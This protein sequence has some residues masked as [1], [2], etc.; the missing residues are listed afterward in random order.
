MAGSVLD[1]DGVVGMRSSWDRVAVVG[2][3]GT[4][5]TAFCTAARG[6]GA[7][8]TADA[9]LERYGPDAAITYLYAV[10]REN[11]ANLTPLRHLVDIAC[12]TAD[13]ATRRR[14][15]AIVREIAR[16]VAVEDVEECYRLLERLWRDGA[17]GQRSDETPVPVEELLRAV[18]QLTRPGDADNP[19]APPWSD[20]EAVQFRLS[21]VRIVLSGD[22]S[23]QELRSRLAAAERTLERA[24]AAATGLTEA[25]R[26]L[27]AMREAVGTGK[28]TRTW[29]VQK[30]IELTLALK[31][32]LDAGDDSCPGAVRLAMELM[33]NSE[34]LLEQAQRR[35][36]S[37]QLARL[38]D[39]VARL[40]EALPPVDSEP[41]CACP[42]A[43]WWQGSV[44]PINRGRICFPGIPNP[45]GPA[46]RQLWSVMRVRNLVRRKLTGSL[47]SPETLAEAS[48]LL[49]QLDDRIELLRRWRRERYRLWALHALGKALQRWAADRNWTNTDAEA[50]W[51]HY[52]LDR[53]IVPVAGEHFSET[54]YWLRDRWIL[55]EVDANTSARIRLMFAI[56]PPVTLEHF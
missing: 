48:R 9:I 28:A 32:L 15:D 24:L 44:R 50:L 3:L 25:R 56:R 33:R 43:R 14:A 39:K 47:Q 4:F 51:K 53:V 2:L 38:T 1:L 22:I 31:P 29:L 6:S 16:R 27:A 7:R 8:E 37:E 40:L 35:D 54:F 49:R 5:L 52:Y 36:E 26:V 23:D 11:P 55:D 13:V 20:I 41:R 42:V 12:S 46:T 10:L 45:P 34:Q 21:Q 18:R 17:E 19:D 30:D